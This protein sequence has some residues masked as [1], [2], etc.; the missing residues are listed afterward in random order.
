MTTEGISGIVFERVPN[1]VARKI[2]DTGR[3][4][5]PYEPAAS[6]M[7]TPA[8]PRG[9][10]E[11]PRAADAGCPAR[12]TPA[13][14]DHDCVRPQMPN[15]PR[16]S[17]RP[18]RAAPQ[19]QAGPA[20]N[21]G[22]AS[23]AGWRRRAGG[24]IGPRFDRRRRRAGGRLG[25][26]CF[27]VRVAALVAREQ[28]LARAGAAPLRDMRRGAVPRNNQ[29]IIKQ[30]PRPRAGAA[31]HGGAAPAPVLSRLQVK[32]V[33]CRHRHAPAPVPP[34]GAAPAPAR[35]GGRDGGEGAPPAARDSARPTGRPTF[36]VSSAAAARQSPMAVL[37]RCR[38]DGQS[39]PVSALPTHKRV[40][41][42]RGKRVGMDHCVFMQLPGVT[43]GAA[44]SAQW[45]GVRGG[46]A[47]PP[48]EGL[49]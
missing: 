48:D 11:P 12:Q 10:R 16:R 13:A 36:A 15:A 19:M 24:R 31:G 28:R 47:A 5:R 14:P 21:S 22:P 3:D 37:S 18:L 40:G 2:A 44:E 9:R 23:I 1:C 33:P 42:G 45:P 8:A 6:P 17:W 49:H 43:M 32:P 39:G 30:R 35:P 7:Q 4:A 38:V 26:G 29:I 25:P 34:A 20:D 41:T 27:A 46:G